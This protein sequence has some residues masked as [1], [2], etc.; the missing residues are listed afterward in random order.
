M[1]REQTSIVRN[2]PD[3][4]FFRL[5]AAQEDLIVDPV[6]DTDRVCVSGSLAPLPPL[7]HDL[8]IPPW[9]LRIENAI[10]TFQRSDDHRAALDTLLREMRNPATPLSLDWFS[11]EDFARFFG[12]TQRDIEKIVT[13]M[14]FHDLE[15][16]KV[17]PART[18]I[19]FSGNLLA[20]E[21]AFR[22]EFRRYRF[23]DREYLTNAYELSI[24]AAFT[25]VVSGFS[26]MGGFV[27]KPTPRTRQVAIR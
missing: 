3:A 14:Q 12:L 8:G 6:I 27:P 11:A 21:S 20:I 25:Y 9:Q 23:G 18:S 5:H 2:Q 1:R 24:P 15:S 22:T 7:G 10:M 17:S 4:G 19:A 16:I 26:D 13:W